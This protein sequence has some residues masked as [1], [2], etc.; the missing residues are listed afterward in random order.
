MAKYLI[1][2]SYTAEGMKGLQ[3]DKASGRRRAVTAAIE[4]LGGR[5]EAFYYALGEN[6]FYIIGDL[7]DTVTATAIGV[8]VSASGMFRT[9]RTTPLMTTEEVDQ[10]LA[11]TVSY[12]PPGSA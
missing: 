3:K 1:S 4:G 12:R 7:P 5:I 11:K 8:A 6:D 2:G 9:Y 10:A